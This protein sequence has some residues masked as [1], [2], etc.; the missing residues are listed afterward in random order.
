[1]VPK[2]VN[3]FSKEIQ[4]S[5]HQSYLKINPN[6]ITFIPVREIKA[7]KPSIHNH[8][9]KSLLSLENQIDPHS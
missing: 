9:H 6:K 7:I 1:M 2:K 3:Y 5:N 4:L 8:K